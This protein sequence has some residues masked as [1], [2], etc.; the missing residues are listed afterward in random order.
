MAFAH[1]MLTALRHPACAG[2]QRRL[3]RHGQPLTDDSGIIK[4]RSVS[5]GMGPRKTSYSA[6]QPSHSPYGEPGIGEGGGDEEDVRLVVRAMP[7]RVTSRNLRA[8]EPLPSPA[9]RRH[10]AHGVHHEFCMVTRTVSAIERAES[11]AAWF[12]V[13]ALITVAEPPSLSIETTVTITP[14]P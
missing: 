3:S 12:A 5:D 11:T 14:A 6:G 2:Q 4:A 8:T 1:S 7:F 10:R 13:K 9:V